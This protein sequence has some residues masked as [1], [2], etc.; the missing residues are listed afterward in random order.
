MK[1]IKLLQD[2]K[3]LID[4]ELEKVL[5][6]G[7]IEPKKLHRA[8]RYSVF[9]GGKRIRPIL[10]IESCLCC[11]G[12]AGDAIN[13]ACALEL[14]HSFSLVHDDLPS[15]DNDAY[16][17]GKPAC[18]KKYGE[19]DAILAGDALIVL[20]FE[21]LV[22]GAKPPVAVKMLREFSAALG[23]LGMAGGQSV[24]IEYEGRKKGARILNYINSHKTGALIKAA[25]KIGALASGARPH[26]IKKM[27]E[28]GA[29]VGEAFQIVDDI[30]DNGDS[31]AVF[32]RA[33]SIDKARMLTRKANKSLAGFGS[34]SRVL[35]EIADYLIERKI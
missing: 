3:I 12:A 1:I 14:A 25:V 4:S 23:S 19:A 20:A 24:D 26:K 33:A 15:M 16:R 28:F 30:I 6:K 7:N 17:R 8:M 10:A 21:A 2:R 35:S 5:P 11:G 18:H 13:A 32:G 27:E 9:S 31:V 34:A 29:A 22:N